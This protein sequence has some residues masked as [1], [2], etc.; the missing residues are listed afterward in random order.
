MSVD[1]IMHTEFPAGYTVFF[2]TDGKVI[3]T[4]QSFEHSST[5]KSMQI[6]SLAL[7]RHAKTASDVYID[8]PAD[9]NS[10]PDFAILREDAQ[11]QGTRYSFEDVLLIAEV[12]SVSSA[13]K[14][15]DDCTT[16]YGRYGIPVYV[17]VDPYA[18]EVRV[19]T[20]P[21]GTGYITTRT[22]RYGTGKLPLELADGRTFTL[23]LDE[24]PRPEPEGNWRR[25][26]V[27]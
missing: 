25:D 21:T 6:D 5:I 10:A 9:E 17:I 27:S 1:A 22:Q 2:G 12:V 16:K 24:L 14:D 23:D 13:R 7:G 15:Y 11:R 18:A 4:P 8:F 20:E 3:M 26:E 19:H